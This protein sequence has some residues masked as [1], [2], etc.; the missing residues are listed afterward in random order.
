MAVTKFDYLISW[1]DFNQLPAKPPGVTE[2]AD[3]HLK[4]PQ[5]YDYDIARAMYKLP[6]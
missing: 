6:I 4:F 2:D 1:S 5:K 3:I